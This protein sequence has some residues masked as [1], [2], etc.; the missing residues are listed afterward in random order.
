MELELKHLAPHLP[1]GLKVQYEGIINGSELS[2]FDKAFNE[3]LEKES[4]LLLDRPDER[5][6]FKIGKIRRIEFWDRWANIWVGNKRLKRV[7]LSEIKPLLLPMSSLYTEM[8][9]GN[10]P[11][12]VIGEMLEYDLKK[13]TY[14]DGD[15]FYGF[16]LTDT[17]IPYKVPMEDREI[18]LIYFDTQCNWFKMVNQFLDVDSDCEHIPFSLEVADYLDSLHFDW[19]Y[20]LIDKGLALDKTKIE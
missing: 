15:V 20:G 13:Y 10:V 17:S 8:E 9:D 14:D 12:K 18:Y 6:G 4:K 11:M 5:I 19:R 3:S 2:D 7:L 16:D 1:Y